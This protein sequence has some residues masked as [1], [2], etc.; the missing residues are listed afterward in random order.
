MFVVR[1]DVEYDIWTREEPYYSFR[2]AITKYRCDLETTGFV[3]CDYV[4]CS[5]QNGGWIPILL[6]LNGAKTNMARCANEKRQLVDKH[7]VYCECHI[8]I[9]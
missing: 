3:Y 4:M 5:L 1:Q 6:H 7:Y 8:L 2:L 9:S